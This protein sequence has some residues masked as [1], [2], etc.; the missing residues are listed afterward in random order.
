MT[1]EEIDNLFVDFDEMGFCPTTLCKNAEEY[2]IDWR[3]NMKEAI[4][5]HE[6]D[7]LKEFV[8]FVIKDYDKIEKNL[9]DELESIPRKQVE[10]KDYNSVVEEECADKN[11][12]ARILDLLKQLNPILIEIRRGLP[13]YLEKFLEERK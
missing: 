1:R 3:N 2:A 4:A 8:E 9:F 6:T 5:K 7:L 10:N 13:L 12:K 11:K